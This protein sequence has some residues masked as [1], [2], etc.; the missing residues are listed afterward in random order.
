VERLNSLDAAFVDA[1]D[2]DQNASFAIASVSVFEGPAPTYEEFLEA[3][4]RRLPLVPL[5][6]RKLR[7]VPFGV[8]PPVWVDDPNF[9]LRYHVRHTA[10]PSPGGDQ[11]LRRLMARVMAQ[12]LD[13]DYPLWEFWLVEGIEQGRWALITKVHHAMVDGVS[14]ADLYRVIFDPSSEPPPQPVVPDSPARPEPSGLALAARAVLNAV[15]MPVHEGAAIRRSLADPELAVRKAAETLRGL[16]RYARALQP[17]AASSLSG[18]I[19]RQRRY[20]WARASLDDV[21]TIKNELGGTVNDVFLAAISSGFRALLLA[22]GEE[23]A[24]SMVRSLVPVSVRSPG[25]ESVYENRLS[26]L[27][28]DLPVDISDPAERLAAVITQ[29]V[30]LKASSEAEAGEAF[31]ALRRYAPFV[32]ASTFVRLVFSIPQREIVTVTTNIPGPQFPLY[33]L[34]R[35]LVEIIPYVP[36]AT[37]LRTGVSIFTYSGQVTFGITGDYATTPDLDVLADGIEDGIADLLRVVPPRRAKRPARHDKSAR[38]AKSAARGPAAAK[39]KGAKGKPAAAKGKGAK[40]KPAAAKGKGAKGKPA[41][42]KGK[43]AKGKPTAA[44]ERSSKRHAAKR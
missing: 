11:Q 17:A 39:G 26:A 44:K 38:A 3:T 12:R 29:M 28:A 25:E 37:T 7:K 18:P 36:I 32:L 8:G 20:T 10:L 30:M 23:P 1:E 24:P 15:L 14:A 13:R 43:G 21:K 5:Y 2:Q 16:A 35:R 31:V 19:G 9:D 6:R 41:A 42:A 33:G 27:V 40:G 22:R 4:A 34:G